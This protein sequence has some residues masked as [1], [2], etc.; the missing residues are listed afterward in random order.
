MKNIHM[1]IVKKH[2]SINSGHSIPSDRLME[3]IISKLE[4][5]KHKKDHSIRP[6]KVWK[7]NRRLCGKCRHFVTHHI[8]QIKS[9]KYPCGKGSCKDCDCELFVDIIVGE[10]NAKM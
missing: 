6:K 1:D 5:S 4:W 3:Y 8:N 10:R 7:S 2:R 9:L